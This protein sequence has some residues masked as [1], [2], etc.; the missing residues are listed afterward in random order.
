ML[1]VQLVS[2]YLQ[3]VG[4]NKI[5][6]KVETILKVK[7]SFMILKVNITVSRFKI[8]TLMNNRV[9]QMFFMKYLQ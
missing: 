3:I 5:N 7:K 6:T 1:I 8:R 4:Q 9:N 2:F